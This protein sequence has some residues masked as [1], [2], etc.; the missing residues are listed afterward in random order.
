M[1][2]NNLF[3]LKC[4][5]TLENS[6]LKRYCRECINTIKLDRQDMHD[7]NKLCCKKCHSFKPNE[8]FKNILKTCKTCRTRKE[9][10]LNTN[11][12]NT[13]INDNLEEET[14]N[15]H[16]NKKVITKVN[17]KSKLQTILI[18]L[19]DKYAITETIQELADMEINLLPEKETDEETDEEQP[20]EETDE[21]QPDDI[22]EQEQEDIIRKENNK[23]EPIDT[24][25]EEIPFYIL[26][27]N[28]EE[29]I[30]KCFIL[31]GPKISRDIYL[32]TLNNKTKKELELILIQQHKERLNTV[33]IL[34][35]AY[36]KK[37][38][39]TKKPYLL[40]T[41]IKQ[42]KIIIDDMQVSLQTYEELLY[43]TAY[44]LNKYKLEHP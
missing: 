9:H 2:I 16:N 37:Q 43:T 40:E 34:Y 12:N 17:Y 24:I 44:E 4:N 28:K 11:N 15:N 3:C 8:E 38:R 29:L 22:T 30:N 32:E 25:K 20:H 27:L 5:I 10:R 21:E 39:P 6:K 23:D 31:N 41:F 36:C 7:I 33:V 1:S 42:K 26:T 19:K 13:D 14:T 18:Y 35:N